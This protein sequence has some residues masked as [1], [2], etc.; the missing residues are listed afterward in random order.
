[1]VILTSLVLTRAAE[2]CCA[3]YFASKAVK[4]IGSVRGIEQSQ[5]Q[6]H[7]DRLDPNEGPHAGVLG[8]RYVKNSRGLYI[9]RRSWKASKPN[10]QAVVLVHGFS[11]HIGRYEHL[12]AA[13]TAAGFDVY[14]MDH[15]GHGASEG[16]RVFITNIW[17]LADDVLELVREAA[18]PSGR[19]VLAV[20]HSMGGLILPLAALKAPELFE[21]IVL[22][23][24][25]TYMDPKTPKWTLGLIASLGK[26]TPRLCLP[27]VA[28]Q[29]I[30]RTK[31][32]VRA[33]ELDPLVNHGGMPVKTLSSMVEG[34]KYLMENAASFKLPLL[35]QHG[36]L[37][38]LAPVAATEWFIA[39]SGSTDKT[40]LI[41]E[42]CLHEVY[43]EC[44][45][46]MGVERNAATGL[47][48]NR[49]MRDAVEWL[50]AKV[51]TA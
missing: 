18:G 34:I 46:D 13:L 42:G 49:P 19:K 25:A 10:G 48:T 6:L 35:M 11:E 38:E 5:H 32:V 29:K 26:N 3:A 40:K 9:A 22:S 30:T 23:A 36:T 15:Q 45:E 33:F 17:D 51:S 7:K 4:C 14:G 50:S 20:G 39:N 1:M 2:V 47:T 12:A 28:A 21:A 31:A 16:D 27:G 44:E 43:N 8:G 37:D 41:Y 24:P